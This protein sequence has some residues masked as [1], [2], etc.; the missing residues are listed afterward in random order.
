MT[1]TIPDTTDIRTNGSVR[2]RITGSALTHALKRVSPALSKDKLTPI[3]GCVQIKV[4]ARY[5]SDGKWMR[6]LTFEATDRYVIARQVVT[7][8]DCYYTDAGSDDGDA[9]VVVLYAH[10]PKVDARTVYEL[11]VRD[12]GLTVTDTLGSASFTVPAFDGEFP[13]LDKLYAE[14]L[15]GEHL[16]PADLQIDS[17]TLGQL[18]KMA[19]GKNEAVRLSYQSGR[20]TRPLVVTIPDDDNF[21]AMAMPQRIVP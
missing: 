14:P 16:L 10:L 20:T 3:F 19:Y 18:S 1:T 13:K 2:V 9:A 11:T 7:V 6:D 8:E 4:S 21:T 12:T 5:A 15:K 17:T